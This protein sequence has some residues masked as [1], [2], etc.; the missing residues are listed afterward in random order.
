MSTSTAFSTTNS[1][2][3]LFIRKQSITNNTVTGDLSSTEYPISIGSGITA[4]EVKRF[5]DLKVTKININT[6]NASTDGYLKGTDWTT[7]NNKITSITAGKHLYSTGSLTPTLSLSISGDLD[8]SGQNMIGISSETFKNTMEIKDANNSRIYTSGSNMTIDPIGNLNIKSDVSLNGR[9]D[10][11]NNAIVGISYETY[12]G[13]IDIRYGNISRIFTSNAGADIELTPG[14]NRYVKMSGIVDLN[15]NGISNTGDI[16]NVNTIYFKDDINI[17]RGTTSYIKTVLNSSTIQISQ[18]LS[19]NGSIVDIGGKLNVAGNLYINSD[20]SLNNKRLDLGGGDISGISSTTFRSE[21]NI[22]Q[23]G[24]SRIS[25]S[26]SGAVM[27][28]NPA[29]NL[30]VSSDASFNGRVDMT[31]NLYVLSDISSNGNVILNGITSSDTGNVLTFN[32]TNNY[33]HYF[34]L[35]ETSNIDM[36]L[37]VVTGTNYTY[38]ITIKRIVDNITLHIP[39]A[40]F[41]FTSNVYKVINFIPALDASYRPTNDIYFPVIIYDT[42]LIANAPG[43][44]KV[45]STGLIYLYKS[46]DE[47]ANWITTGSTKCG[48]PRQCVIYTMI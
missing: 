16:S 21:I 25:T 4:M 15:S 6:S 34:P 1:R 7:F 28:I 40:S 39:D 22:N 27:T 5:P 38:N 44:L 31:G 33:V 23:A 17:Q 24:T 12:N 47:N 19:L 48:M 26:G 9:L 13:N 37:N 30:Y 18:D 41:T 43:K 20:V 35:Y 14:S 42:G 2:L 45:S 36:S 46:F 8:I 3:N 11:L 10:L 32:D 29:S